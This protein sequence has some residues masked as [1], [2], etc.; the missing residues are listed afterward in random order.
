[1]TRILTATLITSALVA[2][3]PVLAQSYTTQAGGDISGTYGNGPSGGLH[4]SD[5]A[6]KRDAQMAERLN[7]SP[8]EMS[9]GVPETPT[10]T[11]KDVTAYDDPLQ[12]LWQ[13]PLDVAG[14]DCGPAQLTHADL[15]GVPVLGD[16]G[17]SIAVVVG[18]DHAQNGEWDAL[19]VGTATSP[20]VLKR[21][22]V[23]VR[24]GGECRVF[25]SA[26]GDIVLNDLPRFDG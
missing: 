10:D 17:V 8:Q 5:A 21:A 22:Q 24:V 4:A 14:A 12:D 3:A 19:L 18:L 20:H 1:M 13:Q 23:E 25:M 16:D 6:S 26:Q 11:A 15:L 2:T 9:V 7:Q